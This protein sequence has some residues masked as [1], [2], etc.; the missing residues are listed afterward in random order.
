M[1]YRESFAVASSVGRSSTH[2]EPTGA[3][4]HVRSGSRRSLRSLFAVAGIGLGLAACNAE[5]VTSRPDETPIADSGDVDE[6]GVPDGDDNCLAIDNSDQRD[7]N[8]NGV[9]NLCEPGVIQT[10]PQPSAVPTPTAMFTPTPIPTPSVVIVSMPKCYLADPGGDHY[11]ELCLGEMGPKIDR[12]ETADSYRQVQCDP[13]MGCGYGA[14]INCRDN[15]R[16]SIEDGSGRAFCEEMESTPPVAPPTSPLCSY[17]D[18]GNDGWH[19]ICIGIGVSIADSCDTENS[20]KITRCDPAT[21]CS[22]DAVAC[23]AD[24][25]CE[26]DDRGAPRCYGVAPTPT[27]TP[28][29]DSDGDGIPNEKDVCI[30][31]PDADQADFDGDVVGDVCDNCRFTRNPNQADSDGDDVGNVCD[32]C[33]DVTDLPDEDGD[34]NT[35]AAT[36]VMPPLTTQT[37]DARRCIFQYYHGCK[38]F[39]PIRPLKIWVFL[40]AS[41]DKNVLSL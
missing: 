9:G 34:T 11:F 40:E 1:E 15:E 12:C 26:E 24:E 22:F 6:D 23:P 36:S 27:P 29:V 30:N 25:R 13:A 38:S 3:H 21:G 41:F 18:P 20:F 4:A 33:P 35:D 14:L 10:S 32:S 17:L 28:T 19:E 16:C 7:S 2:I 31:T 8:G 5:T 39:H 37:F